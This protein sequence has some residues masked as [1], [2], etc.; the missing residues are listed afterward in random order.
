MGKLFIKFMARHFGRRGSYD[1]GNGFRPEGWYWFGYFVRDTPWPQADSAPTIPKLKAIY[2]ATLANPSAPGGKV[3]MFHLSDP[4]TEQTYMSLGV[5]V[6]CEHWAASI[7]E[8]CNVA[9]HQ[10]FIDNR[11]RFHTGPSR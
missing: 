2:H 7:A 6:G 4:D 5:P 11:T 9:H 8:T 1:Y 3:M 10:N